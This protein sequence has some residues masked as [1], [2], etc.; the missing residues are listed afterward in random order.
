MSKEKSCLIKLSCL[1]VF[2]ALG[3]NI[4]LGFDKKTEVIEASIIQPIPT[5]ELIERDINIRFQEWQNAQ[6]VI[7]PAEPQYLIPVT[8]E[9]IDLMARVVMSESS[10]LCYDAKVATA[11]TIVNRVRSDYQEFKYQT[12]VT[13]V[14]NRPYQF[15]TQNNGEVTQECYEAVYD[16]LTYEPFPTDML[17]FCKSPNS[18]GVVY[19]IFG[20]GSHK[21]YFAT[22]VDYEKRV[23]E[24]LDEQGRKNRND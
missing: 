16:A 17:W 21:T 3:L 14:V 7:E 5:R 13:E 20:N 10:V 9:E 6:P 24:E 22:V 15:S 8:Q 12:T 4:F 1:V 23:K 11:Q 18:Y 2:A 19:A